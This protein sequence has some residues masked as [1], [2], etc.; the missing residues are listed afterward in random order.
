MSAKLLIAFTILSTL[1]VRGAHGADPL[2][3]C[4]PNASEED[5]K[6]FEGCLCND[7]TCESKEVGRHDVDCPPTSAASEM[8]TFPRVNGT[9]NETTCL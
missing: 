4:F 9:Y 2:S 7:G 6:L 5:L 1:W 3:V 8:D